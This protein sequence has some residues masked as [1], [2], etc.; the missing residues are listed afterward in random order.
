LQIFKT[1]EVLECNA[2]YLHGSLLMKWLMGRAVPVSKDQPPLK[3]GKTL[4]RL[5][6]HLAASCRGMK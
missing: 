5:N 2:F 1:L 6:N 3:G 4:P